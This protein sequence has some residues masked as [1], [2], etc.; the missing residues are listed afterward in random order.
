MDTSEQLDFRKRNFTTISPSAKMVLLFKAYTDIPFARQ[1]AGLI[2]QP[3]PFAFDFS[4]KDWLFWMMTYHLENRYKSIDLLLKDKPVKNILELSSGYSFRGLNMIQQ[5]DVHYIDTDL[6]DLVTKKKE[7]ALALTDERIPEKGTLELL[8]LNVLDEKQFMEIA[9]RFPKGELAIVNEGLLTYLN[10][11]E[12][13]ALC[14]I[15]HQV[16]TDRGGFWI[17]ADIY[18]KDKTEF[19]DFKMDEKWQKFAEEHHIEENM[20][21]SFESAAAF[22]K[23]MG[24]AIDKEATVDRSELSA[25]P[26]LLK[27]VSSEQLAQLKGTKIQTTWRLQPV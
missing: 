21:E 17:T 4:N 6:P 3:E 11:T 25:L 8:P 7:L 14:K 13:E 9:A 24:F 18:I 15:I 23:R 26:H 27:N 2:S 20:F 1:T 16:L 5:E 10:K 22:F 19:M 12:K